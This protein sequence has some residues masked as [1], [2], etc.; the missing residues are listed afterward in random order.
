[1]IRIDTTE[2]NT[3]SHYHHATQ[4]LLKMF[5]DSSPRSDISIGLSLSEDITKHNIDILSAFKRGD[6][7]GFN[8]TIMGLGDGSHPHHLHAY[9]VE[10]LG[11]NID[12][13]A[14]VHSSGRYKFNSG[15]AQAVTE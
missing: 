2:E 1:M 6:H 8:A 7:V 14:H 9:G 13:D 10:M 4:I 3:L 5:P 12:V 15:G 11:G